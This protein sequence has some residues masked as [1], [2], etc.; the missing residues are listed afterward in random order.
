MLVRPPPKWVKSY[1]KN[2]RPP[3]WPRARR[4]HSPSPW[5]WLAFNQYSPHTSRKRLILCRPSRVCID[6]RMVGSRKESPRFHSRFTLS[7]SHWRWSARS[8]TYPSAGGFDWNWLAPSSSSS[9]HTRSAKF[10]TLYP[11]LACPDNAQ[12][13]T[14]SPECSTL[15][16][17]ASLWLLRRRNCSYHRTHTDNRPK[18]SCCGWNEFDSSLAVLS[19]CLSWCRSD[20]H[21]RR[22]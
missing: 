9:S 1:L 2:L 4:F 7:S 15:Q 6:W 10:P 12:S 16:R 8:H 21:R 11:C 18:H 14:R 22:N 20:K 3:P 13:D 19:I 17:W 5:A